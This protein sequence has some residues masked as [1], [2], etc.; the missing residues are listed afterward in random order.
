MVFPQWG[1]DH[2]K[3]C[4]RSKSVLL[5]R[6]AVL[7]FVC[8]GKS[9]AKNPTARDMFLQYSARHLNSYKF[10][11]AEEF[12]DLS[13]AGTGKDLL[14]VENDIAKFCDCLV[15]FIESPSA[16]AEL[17]AFSNSDRL[18]RMILAINDQDHELSDSFIARGPI[19]KINRRSQFKPVVFANMQN[20]LA[21]ISSIEDRLKRIERK[22]NRR[23]DLAS[24]EEF[25]A[26]SP[27]LRMMFLCD[28]ISLFFPMTLGELIGVLERLFDK[29]GYDIDTEL[30]MLKTLNLVKIVD[31]YFMSSSAV[32]QKYF[33]Y[34]GIDV[35]RV[36]S[37]NI[38]ALHKHSQE[39]LRHLPHTMA[40]I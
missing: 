35:R 11:R 29:T 8:G 21:Q 39:R 16:I 7:I 26:S 19:A 9:N 3:K 25:K 27:K 30:G 31:H 1:I 23:V 37:A 4:L 38:N 40:P 36:R 6:D 14:T 28:I 18:A 10:Y 20:A 17:G 5:S 15:I 34:K 22:N 32:P 2:L 33:V 12:F 24:Y 13:V